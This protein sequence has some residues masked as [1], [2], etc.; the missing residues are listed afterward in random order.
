MQCSGERPCQR[1][2]NRGLHCEYAPERKM[3]G[4]NKIKRKGASKDRQSRRAS[5]ASSSASA[6]TSSDDDSHHPPSPEAPF[7]TEPRQFTMKF[8]IGSSAAASSPRGHGSLPSSPRL[9]FLGSSSLESERFGSPVSPTRSE[10][11]RPPPIDLSGTSLYD[12]TPIPMPLDVPTFSF[13]QHS[14]INMRRASL[15]ANIL[16]SRRFDQIPSDPS[17]YSSPRPLEHIESTPR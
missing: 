11:L 1:C 12:Q 3:R 13:D 6:S 5:V 8:D 9:S 2:V 14:P 7:T 17:V 15:P 16:H 4:P 10:R